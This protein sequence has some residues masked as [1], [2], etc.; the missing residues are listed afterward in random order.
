VAPAAV[1]VE[2]EPTWINDDVGPQLPS[3]GERGD[4][5]AGRALQRGD[6]ALIRFIKDLIRHT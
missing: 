2:P 6:Q 5:S 3:V 4:A 1:H